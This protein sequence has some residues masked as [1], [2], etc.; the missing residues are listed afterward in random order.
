MSLISAG[1][2]G[3]SGGKAGLLCLALW[4]LIAGC[5]PH[6]DIM[7][8]TGK[9]IVIQD[10]R[11]AEGEKDVS[12]IIT[13]SQPL[14]YL[15][16]PGQL[17][18]DIILENISFESFSEEIPVENDL[19][20]SIKCEWKKDTSSARISLG[21]K[22]A[23]RHE[24]LNEEK[25]LV[26]KYQKPDASPSKDKEGEDEKEETEEKVAHKEAQTIEKEAWVKR[27]DF[28]TQKGGRSRV[29][30][31]TSAEAP[32]ELKRLDKRLVLIL[33][34]TRILKCQER[35]L[36]TTRFKSA[37]DR[38][39]PAQD[40]D[41]KDTVLV[42]VELREAVPYRIE[43]KGNLYVLHFDPSNI[44]P[45]PLAA[46][47]LPDWERIM[48]ESA[49]ELLG[50]KEK[51]E[52]LS[53]EKPATGYGKVYTG[54]KISLEFQDADI[55]NVFRILTDVA[56]KNFVIG[57]DVKGRV[58]LKLVDVPW[59]QVM[60]L[61]LQMNKL[62]TQTDGNVIRIAR[63]E[64]LQQEQ[65]AIAAKMA[66]EEKAEPLITRYI[67][68]NYAKAEEIKARLDEVKSERGI[69][70][71]DERTN[72]I[73]INDITSAV[74]RAEDVVKRLDIATRQVVIEARI[75][76]ASSDFARKIGVEWGGS[77]G[78]NSTILGGSVSA[79][80]VTIPGDSFLVNLPP[81]ETTSG[82]GFTF[83]RL[84]GSAS[85]TLNAQ[86]MAMEAEGEGK[87][88]STPKIATL[89]NVTAMIQQGDK[90][91]YP[92]QTEDGISIA[93]ID[94]TLSLEVTPHISPDGKIG[95][96]INVKKQ[97]P[98]WTNT[99]MGAPAIRTKE[100]ETEVLV[101]DG[102]TVAIGGIIIGEKLW[103][104][105]G[106]PW[107]SRIP[108]LGWFFRSTSRKTESSE[109]LIFITPKI[110]RAEKDH[111]ADANNIL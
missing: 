95:L 33:F 101:S 82:I 93:W 53:E 32:Y 28:E 107:I 69:V 75:V 55:H 5:A 57:D 96:L 36:I 45:R 100:A 18:L 13:A 37:V 46:A 71:V 50:K 85:L 111:I 8:D 1:S 3:K 79:G 4:A 99:V 90:I 43:H 97:R 49:T 61:V 81:D 73:I 24:V 94:A 19:I 29:I 34:R 54:H 78:N 22:K 68:I 21:L 76:E 87:I 40:R 39:S 56:G 42:T 27:V 38:I 91:P 10:I 109:L 102:E 31:E 105:K 88:I 23:A 20:Q 103:G 59:D 25:G 2:R 65:D 92:E 12:I 80:N 17:G 60:D 89:D 14:S 84:A 44:P 9:E 48:E 104:I 47:H 7:P 110:I 98:D 6:A 15:V 108:V 52:K 63:L 16:L 35:P 83:E 26:I 106:V 66:S 70:T 67:A 86:L 58:T 74:Q 77:W 41:Q 62:G 72:M 11:V 64:A 30:I 51:K